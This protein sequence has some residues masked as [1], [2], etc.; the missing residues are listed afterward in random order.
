MTSSFTYTSGS[1]THTYLS[2]EVR[3]EIVIDGEQ[4]RT[5]A[6]TLAQ[7]VR[8]VF[9]RITVRGVWEPASVGAT[10]SPNQIWLDLLAG[11][12]VKFRP[13]TSG[14]DPDIIILPDLEH[15]L[16]LF[17][18]RRGTALEATELRFISKSTYQPT[19]TAI[20]RVSGLKPFFSS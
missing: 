20:T 15:N 14:T 19:D 5:I 8:D 6:G 13:D 12:E 3:C 1:V 7:E 18:T 16:T 2:D 11:S 4:G 10:K 9:L 17:A